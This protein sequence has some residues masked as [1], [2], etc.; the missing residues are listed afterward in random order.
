MV[1]WVVILVEWW[2]LMVWGA[3]I[4][5]VGWWWQ[6]VW[7]AIVSVVGWWLPSINVRLI[8]NHTSG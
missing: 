6:M 7:G 1:R 5:V 3:I 4:F 2:S 8:S